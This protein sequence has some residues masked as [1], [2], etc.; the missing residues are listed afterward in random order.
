M[1]KSKGKKTR[2]P[3]SFVTKCFEVVGKSCLCQC[4]GALQ[5]KCE[6]ICSKEAGKSGKNTL[7]KKK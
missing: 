3:K 2:K 4:P 1:K 7:R 5:S 6:W